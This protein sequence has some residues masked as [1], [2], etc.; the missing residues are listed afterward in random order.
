MTKIYIGHLIQLELERTL[1]KMP[2]AEIE[3]FESTRLNSDWMITD[4]AYKRL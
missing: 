1:G 2:V 4:I 3:V